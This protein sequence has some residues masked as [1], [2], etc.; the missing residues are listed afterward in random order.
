MARNFYI[1]PDMV[2]RTGV[3]RPARE[4]ADLHAEISAI[5]NAFTSDPS[6]IAQQYG[7]GSGVANVPSVEPAQPALSAVD[8]SVRP[9]AVA[10]FF[11]RRR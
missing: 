10:R 8:V 9:G 5:A 7:Y 6:A 4:S 2:Y 1:R 11:G 3:V